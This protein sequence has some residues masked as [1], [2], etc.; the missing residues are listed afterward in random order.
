MEGLMLLVTGMCA[1][2][3]GVWQ[4]FAGA[5]LVAAMILTGTDGRP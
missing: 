3:L 5:V 4:P 2:G 1:V